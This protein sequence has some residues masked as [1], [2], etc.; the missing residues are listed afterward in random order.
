MVLKGHTDSPPFVCVQVENRLDEEHERCS[1]YLTEKTEP[2]IREIVEQEMIA[3]HL[4]TVMEM[5]NWGLKQLLIDNRL[6]GMVQQPTFCTCCKPIESSG[7]DF[8]YMH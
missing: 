3:K 6:E 1:Y 8:L 5:E 4:K 7:T 2:K